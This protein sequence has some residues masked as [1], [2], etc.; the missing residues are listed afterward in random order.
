ME[1]TFKTEIK[2]ASTD[3]DPAGLVY[4]GSY[5]YFL[6]RAEDD[7]FCS[8]GHPVSE[9][10]KELNIKLFKREIHCQY[11]NA[12]TYGDLLE[13]SIWISELSR[14]TLTYQ[15]EICRKG[16]ESVCAEGYVTLVP[17]SKTSM[18][19]VEMPNQLLNI[20]QVVMSSSS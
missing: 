18:E 8:I 9:L 4:F 7:F 13:A 1:K 10:E 19:E 12:A 6:A 20:L 3:I 17:L 5:L 15:F 16:E 14:S 2:V 11:R